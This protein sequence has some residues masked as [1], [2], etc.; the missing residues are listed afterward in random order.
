VGFAQKPA[1]PDLK[2]SPDQAPPL[3]ELTVQR[4]NAGKAGAKTELKLTARVRGPEVI[5]DWFVYVER[6]DE[7]KPVFRARQLAKGGVFAATKVNFSAEF[8]GPFQVCHS[9]A[10]AAIGSYVPPM[11][12]LGK[13]ASGKNQLTVVLLEDNTWQAPVSFEVPKQVGQFSNFRC[14]AGWGGYSWLE[15]EG[16]NI[17]V[18]DLKCTKGGCKTSTVEWSQ[19]DLSNALLLGHVQDKVLLVYQSVAGDTRT[20]IAAL[21]QLPKTPSKLAFETEEFGGV[22]LGGKPKLMEG[23]KTYLLAGRDDLRALVFDGKGEQS[24]VK[25]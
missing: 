2:P 25:P 21:D 7:Q 23:E 9:G 19:G 12:M 16:K 3:P 17:R 10:G 24:P 11:R 20:R 1:D 22:D 13:K 14:G 4:M 6:D 5:G 15:Q 18:T 8:P